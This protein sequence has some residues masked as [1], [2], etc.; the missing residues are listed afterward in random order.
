[1]AAIDRLLAATPESGPSDVSRYRASPGG[2]LS[3]AGVDE[4]YKRFGDG[5]PD[6][7][8]AR[9][10]GFS[11]QAVQK[12]RSIWKNADAPGYKGRFHSSKSRGAT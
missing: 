11:V 12:R 9:A 3:E 6:A 5:E 8:I 2:M 7:V 10:M 4:M 1:M